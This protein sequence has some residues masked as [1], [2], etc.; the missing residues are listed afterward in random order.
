MY[1]TGG[2][3][4]IDPVEYKIHKVLDDGKYQLSQ[5]GEVAFEKDKK[6]PKEFSENGLRGHQ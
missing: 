4:G 3:R 2:G 1:E 5:D 6:T